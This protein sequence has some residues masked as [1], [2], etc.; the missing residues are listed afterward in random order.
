MSNANKLRKDLLPPTLKNAVGLAFY[1]ELWRDVPL[2]AIQELCDLHR[3]P[4]VDK[5]KYSASFMFDRQS[6]ANSALITHTTGTTGE[7]TWRHRT[8]SEAA[9]IQQLFGL[10]NRRQDDVNSHPTPLALVVQYGRHGMGMPMPGT[11]RCF[12]IA[13]SDD[14]ELNQALATLSASFHFGDGDL[15]PTI[16]AGGVHHLA[17]LA[18]AWLERGGRKETLSFKV[19]QVLGY[20]DPG[21]YA[22]LM[23]VFDGPELLE[24]YSMTEIFG[25]ASRR[26]PSRFFV[27]DPHVIGEVVDEDGLS[28][29]VGGVGELT[30]TELYPFVQGQPLIRYRTGD[31][32]KLVSNDDQQGMRF[33]L[34]GRRQTCIGLDVCGR[35]EWVLGFTQIAD[36]ISRNPMCARSSVRPHLSV[37]DTNLGE[38]CCALSWNSVAHEI[39]L[40]VGV[41]FNPWL[42]PEAASR[43]VNEFCTMLRDSA[44]GLRAGPAIRLSLHGVPKPVSDF[45]LYCR[46]NPGLDFMLHI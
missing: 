21:L 28:V 35:K 11:A 30:L 27:L 7:L 38:P 20:T 36:W 43:L 5:A 1:Q 25:S 33:E 42:H 13:L 6:L 26:W 18:Q 31:I 16:L 2:D 23:D 29:E 22:F 46:D 40:A 24:N 19:L 14:V 41:A 37:S 17:I 15:R 10:A 12:P 8:S 9:V 34:W 32:V 39:D 44:P 3:L 4:T 45:P